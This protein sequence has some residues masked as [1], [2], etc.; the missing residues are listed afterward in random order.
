MKLWRESVSE[1]IENLNYA[2]VKA[3]T[4]PDCGTKAVKPDHCGLC[5]GL[6]YELP[7]TE[8]KCKCSC[9]NR[10]CKR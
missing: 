2:G 3:S 9:K 5:G 8:N 7:L 10:R 6:G 4:C 1:I